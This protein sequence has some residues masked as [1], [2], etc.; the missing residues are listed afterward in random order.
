MQS[1]VVWAET[2]NRVSLHESA[3]PIILDDYITILTAPPHEI[4][5][6]A[7]LSAQLLQIFG[8]ARERRLTM[9]VIG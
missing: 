3:K 1:D 4:T 8:F 9:Q 6:F 2:T 7:K 5:P